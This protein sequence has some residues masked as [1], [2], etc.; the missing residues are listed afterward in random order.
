MGDINAEMDSL[1]KLSMSTNSW[2]THKTAVDSFNCLRISYGFDDILP[3]TV[4]HIAYLSHKGLAASTVSTYISGLSHA[5]KIN[6]LIDNTKSF[7]ISKLLEGLRR[8]YP[9]RPDARTPISRDMLKRIIHS[10]QTIC[11]SLYE[12]CLF[13]SAFSLAFCAMLGVSEITVTSKTDESGHALNF[14]D[15]TFHKMGDQGEMHVQIR[16]SKT[17]QKANSITLVLQKQTELDI[18]PVYLLQSFLRVLFSGIKGSDKLYV[19]FD[20]SALTRYQFCSV[21]QKCFLSFC[22]VPFHIRSHSFRIV[23]VTEMAKH[24][25]DEETIKLCGRLISDSYLRYIRI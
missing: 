19:P 14:E 4:D 18:C 20:G 25:V 5:H 1:I 6:D 9:Q 11:S 12:A 7:I 21:L 10:L 24:G 22:E 8:K 23:R 13:S 17:D 16:S 15:V 3:A 2:K